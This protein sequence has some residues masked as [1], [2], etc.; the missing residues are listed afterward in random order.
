MSTLHRIVLQQFFWGFV[1]VGSLFFLFP[2]G[3]VRFMNAAG[4]ALGDFTPLPASEGLRFWLSL[5][6]AYMALVSA[7]AWLLLRDFARNRHLLPV[8]ALGKGVS[9]LT[10]LGYYLFSADAFLYLANFLVDGSI[11]LACLWIFVASA[12]HDPASEALTSEEEAILQAVIDAALPGRAAAGDDV[13]REEVARA[14]RSFAAQAGVPL[15]LALRLLDLSPLLLPPFHFRRFHRL[16]RAQ[17]V[18]VLEAHESSALPPRRIAAH[19]LKQVLMLGHYARPDV[20]AS[21]GY[22]SPL[23]RVPR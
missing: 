1:I 12:V 22:P 11:A 23:Q 7:L 21:L 14:T 13:S 9:S 10:C 5:G 8:L 16:S 6:T 20:E 15:G 2:D 18:A 17:R 4:S 19:A 3:T